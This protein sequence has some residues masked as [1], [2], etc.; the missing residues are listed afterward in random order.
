VIERSGDLAISKALASGDLVN[1][2]IAFVV[3]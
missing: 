2:G 3:T 1:E